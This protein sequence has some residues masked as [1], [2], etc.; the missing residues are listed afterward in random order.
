MRSDLLTIEINFGSFLD[1]K[2]VI[3]VEDRSNNSFTNS[4]SKSGF[5]TSSKISES[6]LNARIGLLGAWQAQILLHVK[7]IYI[8]VKDDKIAKLTWNPKQLERDEC[9]YMSHNKGPQ[10][11]NLVVSKHWRKLA[12]WSHGTP[13]LPW[14]PI[15]SGI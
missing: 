2:I 11:Q 1:G 9:K 12:I 14:K 6:S 4:T 7:K 10:L 8:E 13:S 3:K 5:K 15:Q